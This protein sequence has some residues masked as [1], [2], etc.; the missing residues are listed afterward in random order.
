MLE[1]AFDGQL[2]HGCPVALAEAG[3]RLFELLQLWLPREVAT[4]AHSHAGSYSPN[5]GSLRRL[6]LVV[7]I[8]FEHKPLGVLTSDVQ[9]W[10]LPGFGP[11]VE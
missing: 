4:G 7:N 6:S 11:A 3:E 2:L 5:P 10:L 9:G 1:V 8:W